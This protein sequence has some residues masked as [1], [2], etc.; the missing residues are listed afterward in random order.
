LTILFLC[1]PARGRFEILAPLAKALVHA[2]HEVWFACPEDFRPVIDAAGFR[3]L[4]A[5][6][7]ID[8][9]KRSMLGGADL[10]PEDPK[11]H[12]AGP[13]SNAGDLSVAMFTEIQAKASVE[14]ILPLLKP[15]KVDLIIH[16]EG[17]FSGPLIA[18]II[19]VPCITIGWPVATKPMKVITSVTNKLIPLWNAY[20]QPMKPFAGLYDHFIATCPPSLQGED[21]SFLKP[22]CIMRPELFE[23]PGNTGHQTMLESLRREKRHEKQHEK[24]HEKQEEKQPEKV[25][26]LT[27]GTVDAYNN[28]PGLISMILDSL[29]SEKVKILLTTGDTLPADLFSQYENVTAVSFIPH[30]LLL[31]YCDAVIC[32]GGVGTTI[33]SLIHGL[34][35]LII[36]RGGASQYRNAYYCSRAGAGCH[37]FEDEVSS[38]KIAQCTRKLLYDPA[39]RLA[40]GKIREEIEGMPGK[41][42]TVSY[43]ESLMR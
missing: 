16:E 14:D 1:I 40:A 18:S 28:V 19:D 42:E 39:V 26:H 11:V 15:G 33:S 41:S 5:G 32:H 29:K 2:N 4:T 10:Y 38:E 22:E 34:P 13:P 35:L 31:P 25:V 30:S 8:Q 3:T 21:I 23:Y 24:R 37:L 43:I 12:S 36:P 7:S 9:L 20:S 17:E 27:L 6:L